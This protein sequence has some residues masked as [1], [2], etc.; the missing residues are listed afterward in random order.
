MGDNVQR[1]RNLLKEKPMTVREMALRLFDEL[2]TNK[3]KELCDDS[4]KIRWG[5]G[6]INKGLKTLRSFGEVDYT[7]VEFDCPSCKK[8]RQWYLIKR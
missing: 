6:K 2:Y 7:M 4:R 3:D 8:V 1:V 5:R